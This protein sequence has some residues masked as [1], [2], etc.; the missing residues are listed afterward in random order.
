VTLSLMNIHHSDPASDHQT[1]GEKRSQPRRWSGWLRAGLAL[2]GMTSIP[3][4]WFGWRELENSWIQPD[5]IFV[6]GGE[7]E[8]EKFAARLAVKHPKLPVWVSGGAPVSYAKKVFAKENVDLRRLHVDRNAIDTVTNFTTM[9]KTL[10]QAGVKSVYLV[11]S[12]DHMSRSRLIGEIIFGSRGIAIKPVSF[13]SNRPDESWQKVVRDGARS[14][15]WIFTG[16]TGAYW[17]KDYRN[18]SP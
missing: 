4:L 8:R 1:V 3:F 18:P 11:T 6:L 9:L 5:A 16:K 17:I 14:V 12:D 13:V 7:T 15:F 2:A 10:Q